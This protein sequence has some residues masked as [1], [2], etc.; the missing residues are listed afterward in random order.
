MALFSDILL[1]VD[2]DR[3]L[4]AP[5][6]T[7]PRRNLEAIWYFTENGGAFTLNTGRSVPMASSFMETIPVN[8][9][10]LLYNGS[11]A[12]NRE[13]HRL[14]N[15]RSI[16]LD[17][18]KT[19]NDLQSRFP[20]LTVELQGTYAHHIFRKDPGWEAYCDN[21]GCPWEYADAANIP[22]P[23][24]KLA[25]YGEFRENTVASMYEASQAERELFDEAVSY[26]ETVYGEKVD[27]FRPCARIIDIHAKGCSKLNAARQLQ[28][29]LDRKLLIC[30]GDGENDISM[31]NGA[32]YAFCP[33]DGVIANCYTNVSPCAHGAVADVIYKKIP[34]ILANQP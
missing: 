24:L 12:Y 4:T 30:V 33:S 7:I 8:V 5:D 2:Y 23:F 27:V 16:D 13:T 28:R 26:I 25:L 10:L 20:E 6:S 11:A 9:P 14:I 34:E 15:S 22:M 31:L 19:I 18:E 17:P 29:D 3:T 21:N 1:T 32:D